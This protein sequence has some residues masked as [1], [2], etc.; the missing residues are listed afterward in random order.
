MRPSCQYCEYW[1][2]MKCPHCGCDV[3]KPWW[4]QEPW[5]SDWKKRIRKTTDHPTEK[6]ET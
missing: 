5:A 6:G 2:G 1:P 3:A 4:A